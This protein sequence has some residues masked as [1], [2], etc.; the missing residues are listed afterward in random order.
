MTQRCSVYGLGVHVNVPIA[1]LAGLAS[2]PQVDVRMSLGSAPP[3]AGHERDWRAYYASD[4][5][6][7]A[8]TPSIR[9]HRRFQPGYFRIAYVDGTVIFV[10]EAAS[11]IWATWPEGATVEDTA[12]Y[13]LGPTLGF[14]LRLRGTACLHASAVSIG[15]RAV[16]LV[17]PSG[18]GKSTT[19][20]A[21]AKL[22]H[23]VLT[24]DVAPLVDGGTHFALQPAY[25]RV[26]LW[27][28][29]VASLFGA[30]DALPRITPTWEKR[31]LQLGDSRFRFQREP[32]ALAAIYF[33]AEP[34]PADAPLRFETVAGREGFMSLVANTYTS[35]L[36]DKEMRAHEFEVLGRVARHVRMRRVV[37]GVG[38]DRLE[39]LC[40]A[41]AR[42][43]DV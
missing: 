33:L 4:D 14:L 27:P 1:G 6:D 23:A 2:P 12:T 38:F 10:D 28:A 41:I 42:D 7:P 22:G 3:D 19:A 11:G 16:A 32:L 26:R 20:A 18:F 8:G 37:S 39:P 17:G 36:L 31:F 13:L 35:Y 34:D 5:L 43:L 21:F 25:P 15:G 29:S 9:V 30:E 24:D 40:A